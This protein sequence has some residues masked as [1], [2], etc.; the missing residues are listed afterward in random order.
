MGGTGGSTQGQERRSAPLTAEPLA[1]RADFGSPR[2]SAPSLSN[3]AKPGRAQGRA[4]IQGRTSAG[5]SGGKP[6]PV[7]R[8]ANAGHRWGGRRAFK[9]KGPSPGKFRKRPRRRW[10][11]KDIGILTWNVLDLP[12]RAQ[13]LQVLRPPLPSQPRNASRGRWPSNTRSSSPDPRDSPAR[14]QAPGAGNAGGGPS[15]RPWT[16]SVHQRGQGAAA[17]HTSPPMASTHSRG[18]GPLAR[19]TPRRGRMGQNGYFVYTTF[20]PSPEAPAHPSH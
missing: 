3:Y 1:A 7:G 12:A 9:H 15:N 8:S 14:A 10:T 5:I 13:G 18:C 16:G 11:F 2:P 20:C 17:R 4:G 6:C 19:A